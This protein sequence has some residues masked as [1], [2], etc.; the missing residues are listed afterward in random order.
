MTHH[1]STQ[2]VSG[3]AT[4]L[5]LLLAVCLCA[6]AQTANSQSPV[7]TADAKKAETVKLPAVVVDEKGNFVE[8]LRAE[9]FLVTENGVPQTTTSLAREDLPLSYTLLVDNTGSVRTLFDHVLKTG[10]ALIEGMRPEDEMS[11]VRFVGRDKIELFQDFTRNQNAL[12]AALEQMYI[13]GGHTALLEALHVSAEALA[14]RASGAARHRALVVITDGGERDQ[15]S[16]LDEL[17]KLL[18]RRHIHVFVFGLT[19]AADDTAFDQ[20]KGGRKKSRELLETLARESGGRAIFPKHPVEFAA[21]AAALNRQLQMPEYVLGYT[22]AATTTNAG[23]PVTVQL[24]LASSAA[25][26]RGKLQLHAGF[27]SR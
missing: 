13:E 27:Q 6:P 26:G 22:P 8:N 20:V 17:L 4:V 7:A 1:F 10:E 25:S 9:D 3:T 19:N 23:K 24:K 18:R 5:T 2:F 12:V 15:S 16:K 11:I 21:A 14:A